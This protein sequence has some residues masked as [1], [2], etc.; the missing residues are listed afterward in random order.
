MLSFVR[1]LLALRREE[2]ALAL[3][4]YRTLATA[5]GVYGYE[6]RLGD[7]AVTVWLN[8]TGEAKPLTAAGKVILSSDPARDGAAPAATL[9]PNEALILEA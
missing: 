5:D 9:A 6:R 3:G 7:R 4:D 1:A 2:P 8:F